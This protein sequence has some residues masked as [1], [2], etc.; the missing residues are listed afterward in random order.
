MVQT[1][2]YYYI[3]GVVKMSEQLESLLRS[4]AMLI[5]AR[6]GSSSY[7]WKRVMK[8]FINCITKPTQNGID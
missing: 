4:K 8:R 1:R 5:I 7:V 6:K 3:E 2:I